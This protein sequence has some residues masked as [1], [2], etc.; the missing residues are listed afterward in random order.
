[1]ACFHLPEPLWPK[2]YQFHEL[3]FAEFQYFVKIGLLRGH[4]LRVIRFAVICASRVIR[5]AVILRFAL[6]FMLRCWGEKS[7]ARTGYF[8]YRWGFPRGPPNDHRVIHQ[9]DKFTII[10]L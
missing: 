4:L 7:F 3:A 8:P 10:M 5:L 2:H 1:M 9:V 6:S